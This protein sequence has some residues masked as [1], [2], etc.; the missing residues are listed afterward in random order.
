M[1]DAVILRLFAGA[2]GRKVPYLHYVRTAMSG[3]AINE[4]TPFGK[5]GEVTKFTMLSERLPRKRAAATLVAQ[6]MCSFVVNCGLIGLGA[7]IALIIFEVRGPM[8]IAF[9]LVSGAFFI[10]GVVGL[11]ILQRGVGRLPFF[12]MRAGV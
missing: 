8:A 10:A 4:A 5:L 9:G 1:L 2:P 12:L 6:N 11:V 7:P 3:H